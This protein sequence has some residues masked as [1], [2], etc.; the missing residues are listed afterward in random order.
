MSNVRS[1][2]LAEND[3]SVKSM[4]LSNYHTEASIMWG[5]THTQTH[6]VP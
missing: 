2:L 6:T 3:V 4:C 5:H 1:I